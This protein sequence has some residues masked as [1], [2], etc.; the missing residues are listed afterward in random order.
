M[1]LAFDARSPD[2]NAI[3]CDSYLSSNKRRYG[4]QAPA[5]V[6]G[7]RREENETVQREEVR[8]SGTQLPKVA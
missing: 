3:S 1:A 6:G 7:L 8:A 2:A 4:L 5:A